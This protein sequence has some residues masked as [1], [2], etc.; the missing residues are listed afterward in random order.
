MYND[1]TRSED[2]YN[3]RDSIYMAPANNTTTIVKACPDFGTSIYIILHFPSEIYFINQIIFCAANC[4]LT[5]AIVLLNGLAVLTI[6]R[7]TQLQG[8][9]CYF[10]ILVQST[11]DLF[12]GT[13]SLPLY[14]LSRVFELLG[15][16]TCVLVHS[17][18]MIFQVTTSASFMTLFLLTIER[19]ASIVHPVLH[20]L[21]LRKRII[22]I[23][24]GVLM[25]P[26]IILNFAK[27]P[28]ESIHTA[29]IIVNVGTI[30]AINTFAYVKIFL[31]IRNS[32]RKLSSSG[33]SIQQS[34]LA[35][36][37]AI[38]VFLSYLC[39]IPAMVCYSCYKHDRFSLRVAFSWSM[40][41][42][43][44]NSSL[45]SILFFW[46]IPLLRTETVKIL[47]HMFNR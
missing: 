25:I 38:V 11:V 28:S 26:V 23:I 34:K 10:L 8:K 4:L 17:C 43:A 37:C 3:V 2:R 30:L 16:A 41:I 21:H 18:E 35:K 45:N 24:N 22:L 40:T 12:V 27:F 29:A 39:Y 42:I 19:Y 9:V 31:T 6:T 36:S 32:S 14:T 15:S 47:R 44:L 46:K 7:S 13:V 33:K 1:Y 20:R 5:I